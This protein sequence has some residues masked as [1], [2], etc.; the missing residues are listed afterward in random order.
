MYCAVNA[1][2]NSY[3]LNFELLEEGFQR[4][5]PPLTVPLGKLHRGRHMDFTQGFGSQPFQPAVL[6]VIVLPEGI[7]LMNQGRQL[8]AQSTG[9]STHPPTKVATPDRF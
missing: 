5:K 6:S 7:E 2:E 8:E 4:R 9:G 3:K 1:S